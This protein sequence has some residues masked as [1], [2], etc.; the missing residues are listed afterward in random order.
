M[1]DLRQGLHVL[2]VP[3]VSI[4]W[5]LCVH[6]NFRYELGDS[7]LLESS[8][9]KQLGLS[10]PAAPLCMQW[11]NGVRRTEEDSERVQLEISGNG[12]KRYNLSDVHTVSSLDLPRQTMDFEQLQTKFPHLKGLPITSYEAAV[13]GILIGLDNTQLKTT[14]KLRESSSDEPVA[15]KTRLGWTLFGKTGKSEASSS[16]RVL[17]IC[18]QSTDTDLHELVKSFFAIEGTGAEAN[19]VVE[20]KMER[21]AREIMEATTVRTNSGK[22]ETGLLWRFDKIAF[23]DSRPMAERRLRC[24]ETRLSKK[25]ALYE[26]VRK[27]MVDYVNKGYAH[28]ATKEE[29]ETTKSCQAWYLPLGVVSNPKKPEKVRIVWDAAASVKGVSLNSVLL[30]G[31]DL[32]QSLPTVLCRFRQ[33][34]VAINADIREMFHQVYIR[35]E[36]RQAQRFLWRNNSTE[37]MEVFVMDVAIFGAT[38]SPCSAQFAKNLNASEHATE[39]PRAAT[40]VVENHY[41]DDYLDSTDTVNQA[42]Q[43]A[44]EVKWIHQRGGFEPR[45]WLSNR[46]EVLEKLGEESPDASK[47]FVMGKGCTSERVLGMIWLPQEDVFSFA[48][49]FRKDLDR[50][51]GSDIYPT[52][53]ELLSLVMSIF[54]PLG[55]AAN[56]IIHGKMLVQDVWR[57][58]TAWDEKIPDE[59]FPT[60]QRWV[61]SLR[62]LTQFRIDRCYFPGYTPKALETLELHVF[63]DASVSAY[64]AVAYFRIVDRGTV[65]CS[66]VSSKTKVAPIKQLSVPRLELQ[67][68]VLGTR[69]MKSIISSHTL[70]INRKVFWSDSNTVL[71]WLRS[72]QRRFHQFVAFRIGEIQEETDVS[73]WRKVPSGWNVADDA[74]KWGNGPKAL[75]SSRWV[76]GPEFLHKDESEWPEQKSDWITDEQLRATVTI[77]RQA[78][79][80]RIIE[81]DRFSKWERLVRAVGYVLRFRS[82][83]Q[84]RLRKQQLPGTISLS[85]EELLEAER[86]IIRSLQREVFS[87]EYAILDSKQQSENDEP[88]TVKKTSKIYKLCPF[89]GVDGVLRKD[90]RIGA[91]P[92]LTIEAKFPAILPKAHYVTELVV[93]EIHRKFGHSNNETVVNEIRQRYHV[94]ELRAVVRRVA[95][96]CQ[97]CKMRKATPLPPRMS[98]LPE[99]RLTPYVKPFTYTGLDYFG[100][101]SV[102]IGRSHAKR[103]VALFTC[104]TTRAVHLELAYTLSTESCKMAVR[105]FVARRGAPMEIYSDQGT[106]FQGARKELNE[107]VRRINCEL[108]STFTNA[109]TKWKLNP[110]YAPHMGGIWERLVRSVKCGLA[111]MEISRNADEETLLTALAEVESMVNTRPLTYLPLDAAEDEALTPNH[112]LLLSSNGVCQPAAAPQDERSAL[113]SNWNHVRVMLDR[114]WKRWIREYIPVI[115]K[116]SKW[117]GEV[118]PLKVGDLVV[119]VNEN[120]RNSWDRGVVINVYPGKDGRIRRTDVRTAAGVFLRPVTQLAVLDVLDKGGI[121]EETTSNTGWELDA[122]GIYEEDCTTAYE[123]FE[124]LYY[125][126][127]AALLAKLPTEEIAVELNNTLA[128]N[129][130][131]VGAHTDV[132]LPQ[133]SLPEFDGDYKGWLSFKSTYVSLIHDSGELSDVQKFHY[134]KSALKGEAAKL[135]ESLTLTNDNYSIAWSTI[136]KRYSNEYLLKKRH[137]QA[138]MEV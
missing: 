122:E 128:R 116:Q 96:R 76:Q 8:I 93:D 54:D 101:L 74:T 120:V 33:R 31:P 135:I 43:L 45:N 16:H 99:V 29:L 13:P 130:Q 49:D 97:R 90:G 14:L 138:L 98:S 80:E 12:R 7:T 113:R 4:T 3:T 58:N 102:R 1:Y 61:Q 19:T 56:Y 2:P 40:A 67:A 127:R 136:T 34:E 9:A 111:A 100:P 57:T 11:T 44:T 79:P 37:P 30:K 82:N 134:L 78:E 75:N 55:L 84:K 126:L 112:F 115:A 125:R 123:E 6:T 110:P 94:S 109:I 73:E 81:F 91:A 70:S 89:V 25:P 72:D 32:L 47:N 83:L 64:A 95:Q 50:L 85:S 124:K 68:A 77:H 41:V 66:L 71:A 121:A 65:R 39:F 131:H 28:K 51:L 132:R 21:R 137:L 86:M 23:P 59:I 69:L 20:S 22:F 108:S 117:F 26:N 5:R 52:K 106:N 63:V 87:E 18:Q 15:A 119:S 114:F 60:W 133:I 92:W 103:W 129:G 10:G 107:Q 62:E 36:D 35:P 88:K 38:C 27:Q 118:K 46:K 17:H 42:I 105:R 53:R 48:I 24:L 104:L